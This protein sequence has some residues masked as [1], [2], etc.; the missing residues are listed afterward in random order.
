MIILTR[1]LMAICIFLGKLLTA[2]SFHPSPSRV[3][4]D[5]FPLNKLSPSNKDTIDSV[6]LSLLIKSNHSFDI[7]MLF[8][9]FVKRAVWIE[10]AAELVD[11]CLDVKRNRRAWVPRQPYDRFIHDR[12]V[13]TK[14][15][16]FSQP[17]TLSKS[18]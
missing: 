3:F 18:D 10:M 1:N 11:A 2:Q 6:N 5:I 7:L 17:I 14:D 8:R 16:V 4:T 13:L 15:V 12:F 9:T